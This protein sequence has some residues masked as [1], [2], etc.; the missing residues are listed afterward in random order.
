MFSSWQAIRATKARKTAELQTDAAK[1]S[2]QR[3]VEAQRETQ[4]ALLKSDKSERKAIAA[5]D[6]AEKIAEQQRRQLYA[7]DMQ[8][9]D[10]LWNLPDGSPIRIQELLTKWIPV[11]GKPDLREFAWRYHWSRLHLAAEQKVTGT[12]NVAISPAGNLIVADETG[13]REWD[14]S[15]QQF[16]ARWTG[17]LYGSL[18]QC[19]LSPCGR[20]ATVCKDEMIHFIDLQ[21]GEVFR[22]VAGN[23]VQFAAGGDF[24]LAWRHDW[25]TSKSDEFVMCNVET[26]ESRP[27]DH[28]FRQSRRIVAIA[29]DGKS[30]SL[31]GPHAAMEVYLPDSTAPFGLVGDGFESS[32]WS[33]DGKLFATGHYVGDVLIRNINNLKNPVFIHTGQR[34]ITSITFSPNSQQIALGGNGIVEIYDI[35]RMPCGSTT[36]SDEESGTGWSNATSGENEPRRIASIR[37]HVSLIDKLVYSSDGRSLATHDLNGTAK[38]WRL[39]KQPNAYPTVDPLAFPHGAGAGMGVGDVDGNVHVLNAARRTEDDRAFSQQPIRKGDRILAVE[40]SNGLLEVG[41]GVD[42]MDIHNSLYGE[43]NSIVKLHIADD[44]ASNKRRIVKRER[45]PPKQNTFNS[46]AFTSREDEIIL[47]ADGGTFSRSIDQGTIT[48]FF[49]ALSWDSRVHA[50]SDLLAFVV[51]RDLIL[52]DLEGDREHCRVPVGTGVY[53]RPRF[54][55]SGTVCFSPD[56][57]YVAVGTGYR[58]RGDYEGRSDLRVWDIHHRVQIRDPLFENNSVVSAVA[59]SPDGE[60]LIAGDHAGALRIWRTSD[61]E[62]E[63]T[64]Q[65]L[66]ETL[67]VA[68]SPDGKL[69]AQGGHDGVIVWDLESRTKHHF[70]REPTISSVRFTPDGTL[71]ASMF[72]GKFMMWDVEI[73]RQLAATDLNSGILTDCALSPDGRKLGVLGRDGDLWL[74]DVPSLTEIDRHPLTLTALNGQASNQIQDERLENAEATLR[75]VLNTQRETLPTGDAELK[76]TRSKLVKLL[77]R[78]K[79]FPEIVKQPQSQNVQIGDQVELSVDVSNDDSHDFTY[80]WFFLGE[81]IEGATTSTLDVASVSANNFGCY[82]VEIRIPEYS[83]VAQQSEGAYL[84]GPDRIAKGGLRTDVFLNIPKTTLHSLSPLTDLPRFPHEPDRSESIGSFELPTNVDDEYGVRISGFLVPPKTGNYIFYVASDDS[85]RL[86]LSPDESPE[87]KQMI[88]ELIG[89][90]GERRWE[91][92]PPESVSEPQTLQAGKR[93]WIEAWF[94]EQ[95]VDDYFAV[96]WQIPGEPP[97]KNGDPPVSGEFLEYLVE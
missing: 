40:D 19:A 18:Q 84:I 20:W 89:W 50:K 34:A 74:W 12:R 81:P 15:K 29:P 1:E 2:E 45:L 88:A 56:G 30:Y 83:S 53:P 8:L 61:W 59:F 73:G 96:T 14:D 85:S 54:G 87:N 86:F 4:S 76:K 39:D 21:T 41:P 90:R 37:A 71:L 32:A 24:A 72:G 58:F 66:E 42:A 77:K 10:Q 93:Y 36:A 68:F 69:V 13:I 95:K 26:G 79:R 91:T 57:Q 62:L 23:L 51:N 94:R 46:L 75:W 47:G 11:D 43:P 55:H 65:G 78:Q 33:P 63:N 67:T 9:A 70:F 80:Q 28:D 3:A 38:L 17:F 97:P 35:S 48:R 7:S 31:M 25:R 22:K 60:F 92:I 64:F 82:H 16:I 49:P 27:L 5:R 52:W 6:R 44:Q